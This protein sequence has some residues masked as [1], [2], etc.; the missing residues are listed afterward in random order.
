[1]KAAAK[2]NPRTGRRTMSPTGEAMQ[3]HHVRM[4]KALWDKAIVLG[5]DI[6]GASEW[7]RRAIDAAP[8][9][10]TTTTKGGRR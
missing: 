7:V 9:P 2:K 10:P 1:V 4:T 3:M 6:G 8:L 5:Q